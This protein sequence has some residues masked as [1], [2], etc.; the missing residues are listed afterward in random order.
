MSSSLVGHVKEEETFGPTAELHEALMGVLWG[1]G[2][3][4]AILLILNKYIKY[5]SWIHGAYFSFAV[6]MTLA[7][8]I[9]ILLNT[10]IISPNSTDKYGHYSGSELSAHTIIGTI[11][12]F[13]IC[14]VGILGATTKLLNIFAAKTNVILLFRKIHTI[15]GYL[16]LSLCKCNIYTL[17]LGWITQYIAFGIVSVG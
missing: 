11:C 3:N 8:A 7:T 1:P 15:S 4:L 14:V 9:P 2:A 10:G 6:L 5:S 13:S 17:S 16:I 12:L